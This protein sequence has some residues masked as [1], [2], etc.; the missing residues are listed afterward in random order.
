MTIRVNQER[1]ALEAFAEA[2][3]ALETAEARL[4][5]I[6]N[7]IDEL[8][9][10]RRDALRKRATSESLHQ[11]QHGLRALQEQI[12]QA[13]AN[14][15]KEQVV[16]NERSQALLGARKKREVVEK[17]YHKRH[18]SHSAQVARAEQRALDDF[19]TLQSVGGFAMKWQ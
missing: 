14:V 7:E 13:Q 11:M 3:R 15:E 19:A 8:H 5:S 18:A 1:N 2:Q 4:R 10:T 6:R 17:L 12:V 9:G 16:V